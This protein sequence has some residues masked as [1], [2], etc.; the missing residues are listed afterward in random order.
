MV[1]QKG[2]FIVI[3]ILST[4]LFVYLIVAYKDLGLNKKVA[5]S[6]EPR[7]IEYE[8][9][10]DSITVR[11]FTTDKCAA[12]VSY[13][14]NSETLDQSV[15]GNESYAHELKLMDLNAD[16]AYY[17]YIFSDEKGYGINNLPIR[18]ETKGR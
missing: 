18:I 5:V 10:M 1:T 8:S 17:F 15:E 4:I 3:G 12:K 13:S 9:T 11:W 7:D 14:N 2:I 16:T 6:C